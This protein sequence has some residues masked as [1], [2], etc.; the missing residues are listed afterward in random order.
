MN[1]TGDLQQQRDA[2]HWDV[3]RWGPTTIIFSLLIGITATVF[4]SA[5]GN[6][7]TDWDDPGYVAKV[8]EVLHGIRLEGIVWA[9]KSVVVSNWHP[10]T[11]FSLQMDAQL[12]GQGPFG[13]H[14][15]SVLIHA[16]NAGMAFLMLQG[17]TGCRWK[18]ALVA[19]LFAVHPLRV[20][21]VAWVS[22][23]KDVLSG[24]F[25]LLTIILYTQYV[26]R[27]SLG[28]SLLVTISLAFG[29]CSKSM[30]VTTPCVLL[31]LDYWPLADWRNRRSEG[32]SGFRR[33]L[34]E[35]LPLFSLSIAFSILTNAIQ[36]SAMSSIAT[37]PFSTRLENATIS[38]AVYLAQTIWPCD[39][40]PHYGFHEIPLMKFVGA[41]VL[42]IAISAFVVL[43][44]KLRPYLLV[45]WFWYL[46]MLVPVIGLIQVGKQMHADRYT[47]LPQIGL[48]LAVVW[49]GGEFAQRSRF[50]I[51]I[52]SC[53][54]ASFLAGSI[55]LTIRQIT[56]WHDSV[57]LWAQAYRLDPDNKL[58]I[59]F[60]TI[61]YFRAG[62]TAEG[63]QMAHEVIRTAKVTD[64]SDLPPM[65][66]VAM[67]LADA[68]EYQ[69]C[70]QV[71]DSILETYP[72]QAELISN[73]GKAKAALGDWHGA[74][75]D[76]RHASELSP[77]SASFQFYLAHALEKIGQTDEARRLARDAT[78]RFPDWPQTAA[79]NAWQQS[80]SRDAWHRVNF[81]PICLAEQAVLATDGVQPL[82]LDVL[83]VA[84]ANAQRF[85]EA[86]Q[87]ASRAIEL[88]EMAGQKSFA[89]CVRKRLDL[90]EQ[91][92]P[93]RE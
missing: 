33:L 46:G 84:Y 39:L 4:W 77:K 58:P 19:A 12:F 28:R 81:W 29:L 8:P 91:K 5:C 2:I 10:L 67:L 36:K 21:S 75:N 56:V 30:L 26:K 92:V 34:W 55:N 25:F 90:Y 93:Y 74:A 78:K 45:G 79:K 14:R 38:Y 6:Q 48:L 18:S 69:S 85:D 61:E 76:F 65:I 53:L 87:A 24:F 15:T 9:L 22:E 43:Q 71:L 27:P 13:F 54:A 70:V 3:R 52:L 59:R 11:M 88:A 32:F 60:L 37:L 41:L 82:Y 23:R 20:E 62:K 50:R 16:L 42:V 72:D 68:G 89:A 63:I 40:S 86:K 66:E 80:T 83:A 1:E 57:S 47:Y 51:A 7:F 49:L 64:G 31:L 44:R 73:R 17:L 35:K